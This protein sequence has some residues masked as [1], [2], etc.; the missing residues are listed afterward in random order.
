MKNKKPLSGLTYLGAC[1]NPFSE[2]ITTRDELT[3]HRFYAYK[4]DVIGRTLFRTG[5]YDVTLSNWLVERFP[6]AGGNFIDVGANLGYFTCLLSR[7]AGSKGHVLAVEPEPANFRL[8]QQN[9]EAN[10]L[11]NVSTVQVALGEQPGEVS[12]NLY[13]QSN[14]GRHSII[15]PGTGETVQVPLRRLDDVV[16]SAF[17]ADAEISFMKIDVEGYEPFVLKGGT[18]TLGRVRAMAIEYAPYILRSV[19]TEVPEFLATLAKH[20][21]NVQVIKNDEVL[22]TSWSDIEQLTETVDILLSK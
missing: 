4:R 18:H 5:R 21:E 20:F 11:T 9:V 15:A 17:S 19:S 8:L 1:L 7:L 14:R 12:L 22:P 6:S 16:A 2:F 13:K 10:G 3:G